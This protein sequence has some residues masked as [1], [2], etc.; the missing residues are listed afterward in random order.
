[1]YIANRRNTGKIYTQTSMFCLFKHYEYIK[2]VN[3]NDDE[4]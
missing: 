2:Y 3:A 4:I 1:M